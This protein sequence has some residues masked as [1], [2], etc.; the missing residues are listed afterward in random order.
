MELSH[1]SP[2][3]LYAR[4]VRSLLPASSSSSVSLLQASVSSYTRFDIGTSEWYRWWCGWA[5][6]RR[7]NDTT[8]TRD[9]ARHG[10]EDCAHAK[11]L[12]STYHHR[13]VHG[14]GHNV[15]RLT[16]GHC[17][18]LCVSPLASHTHWWPLWCCVCTVWSVSYIMHASGRP[19]GTRKLN[20]IQH[21]LSAYVFREREREKEQTKKQINIIVY[22][23]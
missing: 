12:P 21:A 4:V 16:Q 22:L 17:S 19:W 9:N 2:Q 10:H 8:T 14:G 20:Y 5:Q 7:P 1:L 6:L 23:D 13:R 15:M 18:T 11:A 3:S